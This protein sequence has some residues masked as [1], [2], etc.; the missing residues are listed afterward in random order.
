MLLTLLACGGSPPAPE[1]ESIRCAVGE[2]PDDDTCVP[3]R[4]GT[5]TWGDIP[6][7]GDAVLVAPDTTLSSIQEGLDIAAELGATTVIVAKGVY[8]ESLALDT[9]H[10]GMALIGRCPELVVLDGDDSDSSTPVVLVR[11]RSDAAISIVGLTVTGGVDVGVRVEMGRLVL[12]DAIVARNLGGGVIVTGSESSLELRD[13]VVEAN[14]NATLAG[15]PGGIDVEDGASALVTGGLIRENIGRGVH[16]SGE[17]TTLTVEDT[18]IERTVLDHAGGWG[19]GLAAFDGAEA[20]VIDTEIGESGLAG[21]HVEDE[22]T[23]VTIGTSRIRNGLGIEDGSWGIGLGAAHGA[24]VTL[25]D[26]DV[27]GNRSAGVL[28]YNPETSITLSGGSIADTQA[29]GQRAFGAGLEIQDGATAHLDKVTLGGNHRAAAAAFGADTRLEFSG[30]SLTGG[31]ATRTAATGR[32]VEATDFAH[33]DMT[34]SSLSGFQEVALWVGTNATASIADVDVSDT[35][36]TSSGAA[37]R[38]LEVKQ[39]AVV[40]LDR[41]RFDGGHDVGIYV[42]DPGTRLELAD[43]DVLHTRPGTDQAVAIGVAVQIQA[44][45]DAQRLTVTGTA[46][47]GLYLG[48]YGVATCDD[49]DFSDNGFAGVAL[50]GGTLRLAGAAILDTRQ[51]P[52]VGGG[53]GV[54]ADPDGRSNTI[55]ITD[56]EIGGQPVAALW[57]ASPGQFSIANNRLVGGTGLTLRE[58]LVAHGNAVFA[59]EAG[60]LVLEGNEFVD[61]RVAVLLDRSTARLAGNTWS[62]NDIDFVQQRCAEVA[63]AEGFEDASTVEI[64]PVVEH[65]TVPTSLSVWIGDVD[66]LE[67]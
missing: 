18:R 19:I 41:C 6:I 29:D 16:V 46:G 62:G 12:A 25:V 36:S 52:S 58:D 26:T 10:K 30:C 61:S 23:I 51:D 48:S 20:A 9:S 45:L 33:L 64:C 14:G 28:G 60:D 17:A 15:A 59:W 67:D 4:C 66:A 2:I 43:V 53:I 49:C 47:P 13:V 35:A 21:V 34:D 40:R 56:T 37:G 57:L 11:S 55:D 22:G 3:E 38:G 27:M 7:V 54:F 31:S 65:V 63:P 39:R 24:R 50:L 42:S 8:T 1:P 44:E 5:G 32:G